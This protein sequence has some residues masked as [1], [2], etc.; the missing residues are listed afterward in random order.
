[1]TLREFQ[2]GQLAGDE[3]IAKM[4][5]AMSGLQGRLATR[6]A[7]ILGDLDVRG[8]TILA[9]EAN[10]ARLSE[11]MQAIEAGFVDD[12]YERAVRDYLRTFDKLTT[13]TATWANELGRFS[14]DL[15][16]SLSR[17]YKTI[18][19]EYLLNA[20]SFSLTML[21]PIAQEVAGYIATGGRYRDLV[22]S[23]S[24]IV[25]GGGEAD[26]ALLGNARTA[27][28]DLVSVYERTA[29][30]V[31]AEAVGADFFLYQ[32][33]PIDTTRPFCRDRANKYYHRRE[34]AG[35][36]DEDWNGKM[37]GT[38]ST[39]I[40]QYLGGYN[41]RHVLVPVRQDLV[42]AADLQRMREKGYI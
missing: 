8:G 39:T 9:S 35:W 21:N 14:P 33:R 15:L 16:T 32:G 1:M 11:V 38:T 29:T 40:F 36:A 41:C 12:Q 17:Q 7:G 26:G 37:A 5:D 20:Q 10:I 24:T 19:A 27:V 34:I 13:N 22:D 3:G 28:N 31:A 25:T 42:P 23:V 4:F 2:E 6:I 18:A 30:S